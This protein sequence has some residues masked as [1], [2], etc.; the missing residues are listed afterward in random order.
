MPR[1]ARVAEGCLPVLLGE[2]SSYAM[3]LAASALSERSM[4]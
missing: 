1:A 3:V 4:E 2:I